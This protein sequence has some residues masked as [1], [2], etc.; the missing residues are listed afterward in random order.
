MDGHGARSTGTRPVSA[1]AN[2][3]AAPR[4]AR[5][6]HGPG[7]RELPRRDVQ[8]GIDHHEGRSRRGFHH[9]ASLCI[10]A[11]A[12]LVIDRLRQP[13]RKGSALHHTHLPCPE[14][15]ALEEPRRRQRHVGTRSP[16]HAALAT[17]A[18]D[19]RD[20]LCLL[21]VVRTFA[22][23]YMARQD[24][25]PSVKSTASTSRSIRRRAQATRA[26]SSSGRSLT[27]RHSALAACTRGGARPAGARSAHGTRVND[28][29]RCTMAPFSTGSESPE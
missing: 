24:Q 10:T 14:T 12:C 16:R 29:Q 8:R 27:A 21:P 19:R 28:G 9:H 26:Q 4:I 3:S 1:A 6:R 25:S 11:Y 7:E 15:A 22:S 18:C 20:A 17:G 2:A 13:V 5:C 23:R